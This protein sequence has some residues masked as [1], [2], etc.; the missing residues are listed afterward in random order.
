MQKYYESISVTLP[1][2]TANRTFKVLWSNVVDIWNVIPLLRSLILIKRVQF[3]HLD[4]IPSLK[5]S[6]YIK[7]TAKKQLYPWLR[8]HG[9]LP[10]L[11]VRH[12]GVL[13]QYKNNV[14]I[15]PWN[16]SL[17]GKM[18]FFW[19]RGAGVGKDSVIPNQIRVYC[20]KHVVPTVAWRSL[21]S[22]GIV[23]QEFRDTIKV[24]TIRHAVPETR[25]R[26][27]QNER[28]AELWTDHL[29]FTR[30]ALQSRIYQG[31]LW[32]TNTNLSVELACFICLTVIHIADRA[33]RAAVTRTWGLQ[34]WTIS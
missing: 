3:S 5:F 15:L 12:H 30:L 7:T 17:L 16:V 10:L 21:C 19:G 2:C 32:Y 23:R 31:L 4:V 9:V 8:I 14:Y 28:E 20:Y 25:Q 22:C 24:F 26:E 18:N 29:P 6:Q 27:F 1:V 34:P 33:H 11:S 13:F